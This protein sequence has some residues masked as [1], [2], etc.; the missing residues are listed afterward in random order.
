VDIA[1]KIKIMKERAQ[2]LEQE[3]SE[4][5]SRIKELTAL[6]ENNKAKETK[7]ED[8]KKKEAEMLATL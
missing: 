1:S 4:A 2:L 7:L 6:I 5:N 8:L 3:I